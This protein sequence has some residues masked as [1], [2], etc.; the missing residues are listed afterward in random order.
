[1]SRFL[2]KASDFSMF[3][4]NPRRRAKMCSFVAA[5]FD[6][7]DAH[8][9][10]C[11]GIGRLPGIIGVMLRHPGWNALRAL[12]HVEEGADVPGPSSTTPVPR[13]ELLFPGRE[14]HTI[15]GS[16]DVASSPIIPH[17]AHHQIE[18]VAVAVD[19]DKVHTVEDAKYAL[20]RLEKPPA[21]G[22]WCGEGDDDIV[23]ARGGSDT[24]GNGVL[25]IPNL[26]A[27]LAHPAE[28]FCF[29]IDDEYAP[30][31]LNAPRAPIHDAISLA[32][33]PGRVHA[34]PYLM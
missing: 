33:L 16:P 24:T 8:N 26:H 5:E 15:S 25:P 27:A 20:R 12:D 21:C 1:M 32:D 6:V 34:G 23:G 18:L 29:H 2:Q 11:H 17:V 13:P 22:G 7:A 30:W 4:L 9:Q 31:Y 19:V 3:S 10:Q 14:V 28:K